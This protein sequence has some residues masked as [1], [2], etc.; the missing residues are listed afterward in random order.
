MTIRKGETWGTS[1]P[2]PAGAPIVHTDAQARR[3]VDDAIVRGAPIPT[4]GLLGGD[5]CRT[6][7]GQGDEPR[8]S[9]PDAMT[10]P[11]DL[12][13]VD[14]DGVRHRFVAH[15][16][17]R[18][19]WWHGPVLVAMNAQWL[20]RWDLGPRSHPDDGLLD[21]AFGD[22]SLDDRFK[23]RRR[24]ATG[25]HVPHPGITEVRAATHEATF[26]RPLGVWLDGERVGRASTVV[27]GI[28]ADAWRV[29]V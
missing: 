4:I 2:L 22:L 23:A 26:A 1:A 16:V 9:G 21:I 27:L 15:C 5:L 18:R 19:S 20:G 12:G 13:T 24:L 25:T 3:L 29:V 7:G 8:L 28:E 11:M 14:L 10:F 17:V 6:L